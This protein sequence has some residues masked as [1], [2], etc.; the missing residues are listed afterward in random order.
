MCKEVWGPPN[1]IF[2]SVRIKEIVIAMITTRLRG[3]LPEV[4]S[5]VAQAGIEFPI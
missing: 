5:H 3:F 1:F 2:P 4:R